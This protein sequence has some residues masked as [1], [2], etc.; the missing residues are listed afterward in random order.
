MSMLKQ[1]LEIEVEE[2]ELAAQK[3][4]S[5]F[6]KIARWFLILGILAILPVYFTAKKI[7]YNIWAKR[8]AQGQ[9]TA[10][11]SFANPLPPKASAVSLTTMGSGVYG[12]AVELANQNLELSA[13]NI[14]YAFNFYNSQKQLLYTYAGHAFLLP[15]EKKYVVL[16]RFTATEAIA[17]TEFQIDPNITWQ[18]RLNIPEVKILTGVPNSYHE[19]SPRAFVLEGDFTNQSPY[20]LKQIRLNFILLNRLGKIIGVSQRTEFTV[21]PFERRSYKQLWPNLFAE[22]LTEMKVVAETNVLDP[23][24]LSTPQAGNSASDLS[25][26]K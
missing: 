4:L 9:L 22:G 8:Y 23:E 25:R 12:A 2:A 21:A 5:S 10:K 6:P 24:N 1:K 11:P 26:P 19:F 18:K 13:S 20:A 17:Y 15:D 7:S 3:T 14:S 16:P